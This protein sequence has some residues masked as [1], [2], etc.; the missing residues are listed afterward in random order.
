VR[1]LASDNLILVVPHDHPLAG[2]KRVPIAELDGETFIDFP[3][4]YGNRVVVDRAFATAGLGRRVAV[5]ITNV[6]DGADYVRHGL[7]IAL[8]P[9]FIIAD[10][11]DLVRLTVTE[12]DLRWPMGLAVP[13]ARSPSAAARALLGMIDA[14][15][16]RRPT[17]PGITA[18][19]HQLGDPG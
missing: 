8:L 14:P 9:Q 5:E 15:A 3:G 4:G 11:D 10:R 7:G 13:A 16:E 18:E 1:E 12:A 6:A 19:S 17:A 2:R